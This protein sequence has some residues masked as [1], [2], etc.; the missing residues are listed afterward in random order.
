MRCLGSCL[1]ERLG[2]MNGRTLEM[3]TSCSVGFCSGEVSLRS[4]LADFD[5]LDSIYRIV[6]NNDLKMLSEMFNFP[7][8]LQL[9]PLL[10][11]AAPY[12][13]PGCWFYNLN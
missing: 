2:S 10:F 6:N 4:I 13:L 3:S 9:I 5:L 7:I 1:T 12:S 11:V 8:L